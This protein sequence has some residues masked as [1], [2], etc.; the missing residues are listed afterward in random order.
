MSSSSASISDAIQSE[1]TSDTAQ[2]VS[3]E[4]ASTSNYGQLNKPHFEVTINLDI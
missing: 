2:L 4:D 3:N 1:T